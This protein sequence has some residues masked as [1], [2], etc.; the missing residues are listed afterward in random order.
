[1]IYLST[2]KAH[3][4]F[5]TYTDHFYYEH[6]SKT[7]YNVSI[8]N[9]GTSTIFEYIDGDWYISKIY[10]YQYFKIPKKV[11]MIDDCGISILESILL[12]KILENI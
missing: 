2:Y 9:K 6:V 3:K 7:F 8:S 1:M 4:L 10:D 12:H 11:N 5:Y